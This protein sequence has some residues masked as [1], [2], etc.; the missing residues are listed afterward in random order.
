MTTNKPHDNLGFT[1][2]ELMVTVV[3]VA[4]LLTVAVPSFQEMVKNNRISIATNEFVDIVQFARTEAVKRST[5]VT[6]EATNPANTGN[7]WGQGITVGVDTNSDGNISGAEVLRIVEPFAASL[8]LDGDNGFT[9]FAFRPNGFTDL[10]S[11]QTLTLCDDRSGETGRQ[12]QILVSGLIRST[13][14]ICP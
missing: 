6:V 8:A 14:L 9:Q 2:V 13:T 11:D 3:I 5:S 12:F 1:L 7:E 10:G 4:I